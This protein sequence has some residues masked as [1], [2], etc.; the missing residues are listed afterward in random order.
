MHP[1][2]L[3]VNQVAAA[4]QAV[5]VPDMVCSASHMQT[6]RTMGGPPG[7]APALDG[8]VLPLVR[9]ESLRS[10]PASPNRSWASMVPTFPHYIFVG[11]MGSMGSMGDA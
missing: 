10:R 1:F 11:S 3:P 6:M 5:A 8:G 7:R 2:A 9:R 4:A